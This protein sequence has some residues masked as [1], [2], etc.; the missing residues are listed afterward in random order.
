MTPDDTALD[1]SPELLEAVSHSRR[2]L[3]DL[4]LTG[5]K[6]GE[7]GTHRRYLASLFTPIQ[8]ATP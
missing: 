4:H 6:N 5:C 1:V 7:D 3:A 2:L 8:I